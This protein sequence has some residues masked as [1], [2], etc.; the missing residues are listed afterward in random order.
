MPLLARA[1]DT[2]A[3]HKIG[4]NLGVLVLGLARLIS[5]PGR[6]PRVWRVLAAFLLAVALLLALLLIPRF[7]QLDATATACN[8]LLLV[9]ATLFGVSLINGIQ[10]HRASR[11]VTIAWSPLFLI[12]SAMTFEILVPR[13]GGALSEVLFPIALVFSSTVMFFGLA[14]EI[15]SVR[16]QRDADP[17]GRYGGEE[18]V[19]LLEQVTPEKLHEVAERIRS[20]VENNSKPL[21]RR[22]RRSPYRSAAPSLT[23]H[24]TNLCE[25]SSSAPTTPCSGPS[26]NGRNRTRLVP[27]P[28]H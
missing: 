6:R 10:G 21:A 3:L 11:V 25:R 26:K 27:M 24:G 12:A 5:L 28:E 14:E 4:G 2:W 19:V 16:S 8:L 13:T 17:L 20:A 23:R 9:T 1:A 7:G 18:F 22:L 15:A